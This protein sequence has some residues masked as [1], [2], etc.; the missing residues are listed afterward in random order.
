MPYLPVDDWTARCASLDIN[1]FRLAYWV[2][3]TAHQQADERP[4]LLLIHGFPTSSWDWT[5]IWDGLAERFNL[6]AM[7]LLG[8]G[9]SD[10][11]PR[12]RYTLVEQADFL[13]SLLAHAGVGHA[14]ILAHDIGDSIAQELLA[15]QQ[16][17]ALSFAIESVIFLNGGLLPDEHRPTRL[18]RLGA[19]PLGPIVS[20][21]MNRERFNAG[22]SEVFGAQTKP[23]PGELFA[24]WHLITHQDGHRIFHRLLAYMAERR[25]NKTRWVGALTASQ[26]P[27]RLICGDADPVSG[28]HVHTRYCEIIPGADAVL[29]PDIGHYPQAEAPTE[30]LSAIKVF[31]DKLC[32]VGISGASA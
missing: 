16:E 23:S 32:S 25:E 21:A 15:R 20:L 13:E 17:G 2:H 9:L 28:G 14:H 10:K 7:D 3:E 27:M 1:G 26:T 31:H 19:S 12:H 11:P 4:W 22:F 24:H 6:I 30:T 8:F 18:Q 5:P 29:L